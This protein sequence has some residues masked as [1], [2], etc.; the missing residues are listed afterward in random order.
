MMSKGYRDPLTFAWADN[1]PF[2]ANRQAIYHLVNTQLRDKVIRV[3]GFS[4]VFSLLDPGTL[5]EHDLT[6]KVTIG[7][8]HA[9]SSSPV[10][11]SGNTVFVKQNA[12]VWPSPIL[13]QLQDPAAYMEFDLYFSGADWPELP[14]AGGLLQMQTLFNV[15]FETVEG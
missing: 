1:V 15:Y 10:V 14:P 11:T 13:V 8:R 5:V 4:G 7:V 12:G 2:Q 9:Y 6:D 3:I